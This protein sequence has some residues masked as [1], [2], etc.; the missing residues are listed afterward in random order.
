MGYVL[1]NGFPVGGQQGNVDGRIFPRLQES[2][3]TEY[4][5]LV[6]RAGR[7]RNRPLSTILSSSNLST[8]L[9]DSCKF[10]ISDWYEPAEAVPSDPMARAAPLTLNIGVA[11]GSEGRVPT[12]TGVM[13]VWWRVGIG[14]LKFEI[15]NVD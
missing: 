1:T 12:A 2:C 6:C 13:V 4:K 15:F 8:T 5:H 10:V 11:V 3:L 7:Y 9:L 14:K